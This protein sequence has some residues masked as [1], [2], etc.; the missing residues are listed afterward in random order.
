[1]EVGCSEILISMKT[2]LSNLNDFVQVKMYLKHTL[3]ECVLSFLCLPEP[4]KGKITEL[5][6]VDKTIPVKC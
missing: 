3:S 6:E 5:R 4:L 2:Q 1:M